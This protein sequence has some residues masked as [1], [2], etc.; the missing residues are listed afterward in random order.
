VRHLGLGVDLVEALP[1][2][3]VPQ[4]DFAVRRPAPARQHVVLE[5]APR[6]RL[7]RRRVLLDAEPRTVLAGL[8]H[9]QEVVVAARGE[10]GALQRPL[11]PADLLGVPVQPRDAVRVGAGVVVVD[12]GVA[13]SAAEEARRAPGQARDARGVAPAN[14]AMS[15]SCW[16]AYAWLEIQLKGKVHRAD[17][18]FG[19]FRCW[20]PRPKAAL[21]LS[22]YRWPESF[23]CWP[24]QGSLR[25]FLSLWSP[26]ICVLL[27]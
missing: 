24:R 27:Q 26:P 16:I 11:E 4:A 22:G 23:R 1:V 3:R 17:T 12:H 21:Q 2:A 19:G 25:C 6:E 10:L 13:R 14:A 9:V 20:P 18:S 5:R 7:D 15:Q 8:P